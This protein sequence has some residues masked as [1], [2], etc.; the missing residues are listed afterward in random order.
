LLVKTQVKKANPRYTPRLP[1]DTG[2]TPLK[3]GFPKLLP[4]HT[5]IPDIIIFFDKQFRVPVSLKGGIDEHYSIFT[6][7]N[8]WLLILILNISDGVEGVYQCGGDIFKMSTDSF[9]VTGI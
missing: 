9:K 7:T 8:L 3:R 5:R 4:I 2:A 1:P 6:G